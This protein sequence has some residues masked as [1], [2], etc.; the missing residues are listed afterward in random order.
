MNDLTQ[1]TADETQ[2]DFYM[3]QRCEDCGGFTYMSTHAECYNCELG[4]ER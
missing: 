4:G 2:Y 1:L 3:N